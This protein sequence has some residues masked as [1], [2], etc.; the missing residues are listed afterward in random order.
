MDTMNFSDGNIYDLLE[1][2]TIDFHYVI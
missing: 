1:S 2:R